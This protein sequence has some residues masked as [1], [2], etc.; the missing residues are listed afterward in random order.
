[1]LLVLVAKVS[2][3]MCLIWARSSSFKLVRRPLSSREWH[4][5]LGF[6]S[7]IWLP[8]KQCGYR[9]EGF[10]AGIWDLSL[11]C[12]GASASGV[13]GLSRVSTKQ[14]CLGYFVWLFVH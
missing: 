11:G 8:T 13:E 14:G 2:L 5:F 7:W 1:M 10:R 3:R 6:H 12:G 4:V 9:W